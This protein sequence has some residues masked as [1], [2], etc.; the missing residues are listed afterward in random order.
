M[1]ALHPTYISPF[2]ALIFTCDANKLSFVVVFVVVDDNENDD[3]DGSLRLRN[4]FL[5]LANFKF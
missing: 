3:D 5:P 2:M 4:N 1:R